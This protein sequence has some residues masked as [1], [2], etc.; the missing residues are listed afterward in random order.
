[1]PLYF[2]TFPLNPYAGLVSG[3]T[4]LRQNASPFWLT[5]C[6]LKRFG[7]LARQS[8]HGSERARYDLGHPEDTRRGADAVSHLDPPRR[9][10]AVTDNVSLFREM[11][12]GGAGD[13]AGLPGPSLG[14]T[15][16]PSG[17]GACRLRSLGVSPQIRGCSLIERRQ[18]DRMHL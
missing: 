14:A 11:N 9:D 17:P 12:W 3:S 7:P 16:H 1:M 2:G 15:P 18:S 13:G 4:H 8:D 6:R 5:L 10:A